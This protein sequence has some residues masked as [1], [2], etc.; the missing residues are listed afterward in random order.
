MRRLYFLL[1]A[2][3]IQPVPAISSSEA[4]IWGDSYRAF[5]SEFDENAKSWQEIQARIPPYPQAKNL[6][7][8][9][10]S[11]ATRNAYFVDF[12]SVST[13]TDG[14]VRYT[15]VIRSPAGAET[16]S[17][18]GMRCENGERKLYAFGRSDGQGGGEWSRNR[19]ARW[20][21]IKERQQTSYQKELFYHYFCTVEGHG[22]LKAIQRLLRSGGLYDR[23]AGGLFPR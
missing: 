9:T 16:V 21:T 3:L 19:F 18:E 10:V 2:A 20:E 13:G 8:F 12:P 17:Y 15:V 22:D 7:P 1:A 4:L 14:V 5:E 23:D 11:A 6:V